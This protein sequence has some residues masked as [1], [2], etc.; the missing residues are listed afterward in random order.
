MK[1]TFVRRL[2]AV[3]ADYQRE[4]EKLGQDEI[5]RRA[6][7]AGYSLSQSSVSRWQNGN[8][9]PT[10]GGVEGLAA[11]L[12]VTPEWLAWGRGKKLA[13]GHRRETKVEHSRK[14]TPPARVKRA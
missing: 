10:I 12:G 8:A 6:A 14:T 3:L 1:D 9:E 13:K 4:R 5:V 2:A 11:A 7:A